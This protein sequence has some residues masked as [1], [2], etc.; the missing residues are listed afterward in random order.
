MFSPVATVKVL[1]DL[2]SIRSR[3]PFPAVSS[4]GKRSVI[5]PGSLKLLKSMPSAS[6]VLVPAMIPIPGTG[7]SSMSGP[8]TYPSGPQTFMLASKPST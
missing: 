4:D 5:L 3:V 2:V 7:L 8:I 1:P 6:L